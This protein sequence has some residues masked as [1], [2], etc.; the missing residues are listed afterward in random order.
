MYPKDNRHI[1]RIYS[2]ISIVQRL[3]KEGRQATELSQRL[4]DFP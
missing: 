4:A 1:R 3:R 2:N